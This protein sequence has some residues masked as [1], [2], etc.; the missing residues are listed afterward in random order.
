MSSTPASTGS[1]SAGHSPTRGSPPGT[2]PSASPASNGRLYVSY[3]KQDAQR[4]DDVSGPGHGFID[5]YSQQ[6]TLLRRLVSRGVLDSPWGM[7]IA[8][9]GFGTFSNDLLVGNF[10][11]G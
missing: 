9:P 5:V 2:R 6:G 4:H 11:D 7:V 8:P 10:G 1:R 3:A